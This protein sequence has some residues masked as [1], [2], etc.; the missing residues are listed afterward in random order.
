MYQPH[1]YSSASDGEQSQSAPDKTNGYDAK[2]VDPLEAKRRIIAS[3][4]DEAAVTGPKTTEASDST[5]VIP[6][7]NF[8]T[9]EPV[10][11][12][13]GPAALRSLIQEEADT[14]LPPTLL[15]D[16]LWESRKVFEHIRRAAHSR[17]VSA[18]VV[19]HCVLA[20]V[21]AS[22]DHTTKL[23]ATVGS[24]APLCFFTALIG[25]SGSGKSSGY[26]VAAELVPVGNHVLELPPGSGEGMVDALFDMV[27]E[28]DPVTDKPGKPV[29]RQVRFNATVFADEGEIITALSSRSGST[30]L[31]TYRTIWTGGILGQANA[32]AE[33]KR[34]VPAGQYAFGIAV[35]LQP[36]KAAELLGD[37]DGGTPQRFA[38]ASAIDPNIPDDSPT[39]P[40]EL[41]WDPP[42][43][44]AG[45]RS[46]V[47]GSCR[48]R[49][50]STRPS[51]RRSA[52]RT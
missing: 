23:P 42:S 37:V 3:S 2:G 27:T 1:Q 20:R 10:E 15:P 32:S 41:E 38:W 24:H 26:A 12:P 16:S 28:I 44:M 11:T 9:P 33:R 25:R 6:L 43:A 52:R 30:L 47:R 35:G 46:S 29:K 49:W 36:S 39:W 40:G 22:V 18:D 4:F 50:W 5:G 51:P 19:L 7:R 21:A 17:G 48:R 31:S 14:P 34:I 45:T 13:K 8:D